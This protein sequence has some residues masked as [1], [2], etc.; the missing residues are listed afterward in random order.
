MIKTD[1][2]STYIQSLHPSRRQVAG[3]VCGIV[4]LTQY[5]FT[6][7]ILKIMS[8][9]SI[10][11]MLLEVTHI[12]EREVSGHVRANLPSTFAN[13]TISMPPLMTCSIMLEHPVMKGCVPAVSRKHQSTRERNQARPSMRSLNRELHKTSL[14]RKHLQSCMRNMY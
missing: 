7:A 5:P 4:A 3:A 13:S 11:D 12:F 9:A 10:Y 1:F 6:N 8:L 14:D 2:L